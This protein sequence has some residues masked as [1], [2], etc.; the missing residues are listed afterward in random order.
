MHTRR[1]WELRAPGVGVHRSP[2][3]LLGWGLGARTRQGAEN[4]AGAPPRQPQG[5]RNCVL[6]SL[7]PP[8]ASLWRGPREG[9]QALGSHCAHHQVGPPRV[10]GKD[11]NHLLINSQVPWTFVTRPQDS[12]CTQLALHNVW[13]RTTG[14]PDQPAPSTRTIGLGQ[15]PPGL[16][17][18]QAPSR[19]LSSPRQSEHPA[20]TSCPEPPGTFL[21]PRGCPSAHLARPGPRPDRSPTV[22]N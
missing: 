9:L 8:M 22:S 12:S 4:E 15:A 2:A 18:A 5:P 6:W 20:W 21:R 19:G 16:P 1:C 14:A 13:Q 10:L 3:G 17:A 11:Q 7:S